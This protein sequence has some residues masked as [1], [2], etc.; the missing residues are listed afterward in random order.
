MNT[1]A[2][3]NPK[4]KDATR[5]GK[6]ANKRNMTLNKKVKLKSSAPAISINHPATTIAQAR[7][8]EGGKSV[9]QRYDASINNVIP[10]TSIKE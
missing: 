3:D 8:N 6:T 1:P 2:T 7:I 4:D 9:S 5:D 10:P